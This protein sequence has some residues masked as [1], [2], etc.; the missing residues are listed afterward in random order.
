VPYRQW[1]EDLGFGFQVRLSVLRRVIVCVRDN[2]SSR[3]STLVNL[4]DV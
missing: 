2:R 1:P 3:S 4:Q